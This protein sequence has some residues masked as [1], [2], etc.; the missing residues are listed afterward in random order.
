MPNIYSTEKFEKEFTYSG[1]DLGATYTPEKTTF[2]VWAPTADAVTLN[3]YGSGTPGTDDLVEQLPMTAYV[4]GTWIAEKE[5]DLNGTYYT[6]LVSVGGNENEACDPYA[7]ATG[8]NGKR[9]MVLDLSSTNPKGWENDTN[10]NAG[11][12]YNDAIIYELHVRD[13]SSDE[14]FRYSEHRKIFR[15]Y[16]NRN[17]NC[18]RHS[19]RL[20]PH[21]GSWHHPS[22]SAPGL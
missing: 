18:F 13:L 14:R 19:N 2:R 16:R 7:R 22:A 21:E 17:N 9:A 12:T 10:P 1:S 3:L 11:M 5:G 15:S 6:Y 20:R 8:V 4:N